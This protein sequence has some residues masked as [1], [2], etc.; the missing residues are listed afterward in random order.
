[1][2]LG[3]NA[4]SHETRR[5]FSRNAKVTRRDKSSSN[6]AATR[7]SGETVAATFSRNALTPF[8]RHAEPS[9]RRAIHSA[10]HGAQRCGRM[11]SKHSENSLHHLSAWRSANKPRCLERFQKSCRRAVCKGR[12]AD[13]SVRFAVGRTLRENRDPPIVSSHRDG[14][15]RLLFSFPS[16]LRS[17]SQGIAVERATTAANVCHL[18]GTGTRPMTSVHRGGG[19]TISLAIQ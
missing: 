9:R 2:F 4:A 17:T 12:G 19:S 7:P 11:F 15:C 6:R 16:R 1:M 18:Y 3:S 14:F 8:R 13:V 10:C 5:I